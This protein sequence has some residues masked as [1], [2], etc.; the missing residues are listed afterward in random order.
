[1]IWHDALAVALLVVVAALVGAVPG[2]TQAVWQVAACEL[3]VIMQVVVVEV[4]GVESPV[5]GVVTFGVVEVCANA[6]SR[7]PKRIAAAP[8][9]IERAR[10][11]P[12]PV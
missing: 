1:M 6:A 5:K 11:M 9:T 2:T 4:S 8:I 12:P 3:Q 10:M 7:T